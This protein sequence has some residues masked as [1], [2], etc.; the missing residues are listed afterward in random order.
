MPKGAATPFGD[1]PRALDAKGPGRGSGLWIPT[2]VP[3]PRPSAWFTNR[4]A[5]Q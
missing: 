3:G 5:V 1:A 2:P 4:V